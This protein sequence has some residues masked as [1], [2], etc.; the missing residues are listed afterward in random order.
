MNQPKRDTIFYLLS[1][2]CKIALRLAKALGWIRSLTVS[3][4]LIFFLLPVFEVLDDKSAAVYLVMFNLAII[5]GIHFYRSDQHFIQSLGIREQWL[6]CVEYLLIAL[7]VVLLLGYMGAWLWILV[8]VVCCFT[9]PWIPASHRA[10]RQAKEPFQIPFAV[11]YE[12]TSGLRKHKWTLIVLFVLGVA[13]GVLN[14]FLGWIFLFFIT[15][16]TALFYCYCEPAQ[17]ILLKD[18]SPRRFIGQKLLQGLGYYI[19][20]TGL[21]WL[22]L[23]AL[24][25][26]YAIYSI[27]FFLG[28]LFLLATV[29]TGKYA[30]YR[31]NVNI[32]MMI[33]MIFCFGCICLLV[34]YLPPVLL[35]LIIWLCWRGTT[36]LREE[37][38]AFH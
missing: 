4:A 27:L 10:A 36:R 32:E 31:A 8:S 37:V 16:I 18:Q 17:L 38:Y 6:F 19:C 12:W 23:I 24:H 9:I 29:I 34:P 21:L 3:V 28:N 7:P 20:L 5:A 22:G 30:F 25:P 2:R 13:G 1:L 14:L 26:G 33:S 35:L 15:A 11:S